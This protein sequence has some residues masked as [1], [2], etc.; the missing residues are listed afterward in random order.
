MEIRK[1]SENEI[2]RAIELVWNVFL[3][4]E[5][6][7]YTDEGIEEFKKSINDKEWS[8]QRDFYG[9]FNDG[10]LSG[11]IATKD[12]SHIALFFVDGNY[13]KQGIGRKLYDKIKSLNQKGFFTVNSSPYAHEVYK[14]LGFV[15]TN[16]EQCI[17][18]LRFYP[19][20]IEF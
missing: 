13:H 10:V 6:P 9:A 17:N 20:R 19:M 12:K 7:D 14:H 5:A 18:G 2:S 4:Y 1:V 8:S 3:E 15:D 16:Q 11:V